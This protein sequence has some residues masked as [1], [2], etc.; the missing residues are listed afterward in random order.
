MKEVVQEGPGSRANSSLISIAGKTGTS[1]TLRTEEGNKIPEKIAWFVGYAPAEAP[2]Y[3]FAVLVEGGTSGGAT[4][5]PIARH[6]ME[7]V[8]AGLPAPQPQ[9]ASDGH[10]EMTPPGDK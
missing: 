10:F 6:I 9:P 2:R 8:A 3:A 1:Q 5:A 7:A 4:A